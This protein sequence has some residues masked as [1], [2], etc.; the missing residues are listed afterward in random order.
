MECR[1]R[2]LRPLLLH[3]RYQPTLLQP[4]RQD[5]HTIDNH[6]KQEAISHTSGLIINHS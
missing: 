2:S 1:K 3:L 5:S 6:M 4:Q